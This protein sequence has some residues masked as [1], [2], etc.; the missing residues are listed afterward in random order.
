[1]SSHLKGIEISS[2]RQKG[3]L[4]TNTH[5][6]QQR[7]NIRAAALQ[8]FLKKGNKL[9]SHR[10]RRT[11]DVG[12]TARGELLQ[13]FAAKG[14]GRF[15]NLYPS[16]PPAQKARNTSVISQFQGILRSMKQALGPNVP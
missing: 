11:A 13:V 9:R 16:P 12:G 8:S 6:W 3:K 14:K 1:M 2:G 10:A 7:A 15:S 4:N 5:Y